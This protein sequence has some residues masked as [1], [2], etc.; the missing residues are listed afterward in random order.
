MS[1]QVKIPEKKTTEDIRAQRKHECA[2]G[3]QLL[4]ALK[5]GD[6]GDGHISARDPV[7]TDCFWMLPYGAAYQSATESDLILVS[8]KGTTVEGDGAVNMAGYYIHHPILA[9]RPDLVSAVHVHTGWGT[10][11][12]SE[13]RPIQ[14]ISQEACIFFEDHAIFDD[15]EVQI[16]SVDAGKRIADKLAKSRAIILRNHG[17]LTTGDSVA[18]AVGSFVL[19]ERVAEVHMKVNN[20]KTISASA[21][22]F[23]KQDLIKGGAG[24]MA[25]ASLLKRHIQTTTLN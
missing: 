24:R 9:A 7:H 1:E 8:D 21:A 23:A 16:Q 13:V 19:L 25:F 6:L 22:R 11:F 4:A 17:L 12:S 14:P 10:P 3:Y 5:W 18:E 20:P 15:D 2:L